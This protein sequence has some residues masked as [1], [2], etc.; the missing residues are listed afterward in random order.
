MEC[1]IAERH[2]TRPQIPN[3]SL[4]MNSFFYLAL[5][6]AST[7]SQE[8]LIIIKD[9]AVPKET[10]IVVNDFAWQATRI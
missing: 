7:S 2:G 5:P 4:T 9:K 10:A 3:S 1:E 6:F 8:F